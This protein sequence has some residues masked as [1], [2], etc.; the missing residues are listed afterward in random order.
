MM[1]KEDP[2]ISAKW[3][4][5]SEEQPRTNP[6]TPPTDVI[7]I[8]E[9]KSSSPGEPN[10]NRSIEPLAG[11]SRHPRYLVPKF[12]G[13]Y[14]VHKG[15]LVIDCHLMVNLLPSKGRYFYFDLGASSWVTGAGGVSQ[16]WFHQV[17]T[18]CGFP[19]FNGGYFMWEVAYQHP[20]NFWGPIPA[21]IKPYYHWYNVPASTAQTPEN[22]LQMIK[23]L[24][25]KEDFLV[26][27]IDIDSPNIEDAF[28]E[29]ILADPELMTLIDD[30]FFEHHVNVPEMGP[31]GIP[32]THPVYLNATYRLFRKLR[33]GGI[34]AHSW[35]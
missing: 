23:K 31:W 9:Y 6:G 33:L 16:A 10:Q 30:M 18:K 20:G 19:L 22:P 7:S 35:V 14:L 3:L 2:N 4:G 17:Y 21:V 12:D 25:K 26:L 15:Y 32:A 28:I 13:G 5:F 24:V 27:K 1:Q 11:L 34:V 8:M 29:Q